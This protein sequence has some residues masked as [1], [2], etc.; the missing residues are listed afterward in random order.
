MKK[1]NSFRIL[2][3]LDLVLQSNREQLEGFYRHAESKSNWNVQ[4]VPNLEESGCVMVKG[5]IREGIDGI[6][7]KSDCPASMSDVIFAAKVPIVFVD[8]PSQQVVRTA[9]AYVS[10]DNRSL[11]RMAAQYFDSLGRFAAYGFVPDPEGHEWSK[12][13]GKTF[14][15]EMSRRHKDAN[16]SELRGPITE[17]IAAQP[18]PFAVFAAFD[19]CATAVFN[20]CRTLHLAIP[21]NVAVLGVDDDALICEHT[22]P[23]LSSI[24]INTVMQGFL[25]AKE[26]DRILSGR[27]RRRAPVSCQHL[28]ISER[29]STAPVQPGLR[30]VREV[31]AYLDKHALKP[32]CVADVVAHAGVSARLANLRYSQ[33]TGHSIQEELVSRRLEEAKRLLVQTSWPMTRVA[34]R[35][36]FRSQGVL[37][38]LFSAHFGMSMR[39]YRNASK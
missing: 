36:G 23:K 2:V 38:N 3:V 13:R 22:R 15:A 18:K 28:G 24:R 37:S 32:I 8:R 16:V 4:I 29:D 31:N 1:K 19:R 12:V 21:K 34:I 20:A 33:S 17:W 6:I 26:L 5:I 7:V 35:C 39:S 25:A 14:M 27:P 30:V 10:H 9:H 11:G